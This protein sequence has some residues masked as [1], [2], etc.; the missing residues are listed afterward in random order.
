MARSKFHELLN[1]L[2]QSYWEMGK[3]YSTLFD[4]R[5]TGDYL[6]MINLEKEK[7]DPLIPKTEDFIRR[8]KILI[9]TDEP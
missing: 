2:N 8:I 3:L 4:L 7:I 5:N 6:D 1:K 9:N